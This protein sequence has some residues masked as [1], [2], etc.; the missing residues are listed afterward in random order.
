MVARLIGYMENYAYL[1]AK[2]DCHI[3]ERTS[4]KIA[5]HELFDMIAGSESGAIIA[6]SLMLKNPDFDPDLN[7]SY[8]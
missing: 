8:S 3:K 7:I 5:M 2:R 4:E 6:S 1:I